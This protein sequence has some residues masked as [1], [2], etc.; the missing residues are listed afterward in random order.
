MLE[1]KLQ[2]MFKSG[3]IINHNPILIEYPKD[4]FERLEPR[5]SKE[6]GLDDYQIPQAKY[7]SPFENLNDFLGTN[8]PDFESVYIWNTYDKNKEVIQNPSMKI[9]DNN[10]VSIDNL[11]I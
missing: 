5:V 8:N 2:Y 3:E 4:V 9:D 10:L 11:I 1:K 6:K 7:F